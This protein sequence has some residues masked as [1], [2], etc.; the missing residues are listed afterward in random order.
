MGPGDQ[1]SLVGLDLGYTLFYVFVEVFVRVVLTLEGNHHFWG[2][3]DLG[4]GPDFTVLDFDVPH[5]QLYLVQ[6]GYRLRV[7]VAGL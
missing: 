4:G 3:F 6:L 7:N 5:F 1:A 2:F